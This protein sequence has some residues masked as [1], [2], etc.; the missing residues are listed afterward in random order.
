[1]ELRNLRNTPNYSEHILNYSGDEKGTLNRSSSS[2]SEEYGSSSR[3]SIKI[4]ENKAFDVYSN[5]E[6][7]E[8]NEII[9]KGAKDFREEIVKFETKKIN[10]VP[11]NF[12]GNVAYRGPNLDDLN[13]SSISSSSEYL[14]DP[15]RNPIEPYAK[16][17]NIL[18]PPAF[19]SDP[20]KVKQNKQVIVDN[21][22]KSAP[23]TKNPGQKIIKVAEEEQKLNKEDSNIKQIPV[24]I[25]EIKKSN[26][27]VSK[28]IEPNKNPTDGPAVS[29]YKN[30]FISNFSI[31]RYNKS[32]CEKICSKRETNLYRL[33]KLIHNESGNEV[34][35]QKLKKFIFDTIKSKPYQIENLSIVELYM[36]SSLLEVNSRI[37]DKS[38][39]DILRLVVRIINDSISNM[40]N[41][42]FKIQNYF[43]RILDFISNNL[44][45]SGGFN[46]TPTTELLKELSQL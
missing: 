39:D 8:K 9:G 44:D 4:E 10:Q 20:V 17:S 3:P 32:F 40:T 30:E 42:N 6:V 24:K 22:F 1:M 41:E 38:I 14:G 11:V 21:F 34:N 28:A 25:I 2:S 5:K 13:T 29:I 33:K 23:P 15:N 46:K 35:K 12:T 26:E 45:L 18:P 16:Q 27:P 37:N 43:E 19:K 31:L 7:L 36:V